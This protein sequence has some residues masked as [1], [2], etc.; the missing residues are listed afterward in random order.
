MQTLVYFITFHVIFLS[1]NALPSTESMF[2]QEDSA[3]VQEEINSWDENTGD[4]V[5]E[6]SGLDEGDIVRK[7]GRNGLRSKSKRWTLGI[8]PYRIPEGHFSESELAKIQSILD[9]YNTITCLQFRP[10]VDTDENFIDI[11]ASY[12]GC[13][14]SV[15]ME[16]GAQVLNLQLPHCIRYGTIRH[17]LMHAIGFEH[18]Q[19]SSNRDQF[20]KINWENIA[21]KKKHNFVKYPASRVQNFG[22]DYDYNS[23]MHYSGV[24]FSKNGQPT[25]EPRKDGVTLVRKHNFSEGDLIK[26]ENMYKEE[27]EKRNK[28]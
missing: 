11:V 16:G 7:V 26:L 13:W 21:D 24:A 6:H 3:V 10:M 22:L 20:L 15:G 25:M 4:N 23:I 19:S 28:I 17:E 2:G 12:A 9:E 1:A 8:I 27:C 18:Q 5:W 14:S